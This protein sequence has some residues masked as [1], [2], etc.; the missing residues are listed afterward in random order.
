MY[1]ILPLEG[2]KN[3]TAK[4]I[5]GRVKNEIITHNDYKQSLFNKQQFTHKWSGIQQEKHE[6]YTVEVEKKSLSPFN[7][8]KWITRDGDIFTSYSFGHYKIKKWD[9]VWEM[10]KVYSYIEKMFKIYS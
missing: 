4:G 5:D 6:L 7:D 9:N 3:A 2:W 10:I 1:S 8:K